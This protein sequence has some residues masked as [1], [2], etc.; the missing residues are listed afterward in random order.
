MDMMNRKAEIRRSFTIEDN[1]DIILPA[2]YRID[3]LPEAIEEVSEFGSFEIRFEA[4][5]E[6][7]LHIYR[8]AIILKGNHEKETFDRFYDTLKKIKHIEQKK[9]VLQGK[10]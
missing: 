7:V 10:T 9:I 6:N 1:V 2:N 5:D 3:S 8:R 4:D